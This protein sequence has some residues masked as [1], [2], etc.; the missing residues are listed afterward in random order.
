MIFV[1]DLKRAFSI[2]F[3]P[4]DTRKQDLGILRSLFLYYRAT[5]IAA[6]IMLLVAAV[7]ILYGWRILEPGW[8]GGLNGP[9]EDSA[10]STLISLWV[11]LPLS[12]FI[13]AGFCQFF[14]RLL[15]KFKKKYSKTLSGVIVG[16]VPA[17][18]FLLWTIPIIAALNAANSWLVPEGPGPHDLLLNNVGTFSLLVFA[19]AAICFFIC[20]SFAVANRQS[21]SRKA[22][23]GILFIASVV[24]YVLLTVSG[25]VYQSM[26]ISH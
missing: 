15:N 1:S 18:T 11:W 16:F 9:T 13:F 2:I 8:L 26:V 25:L 12:A 14:G 10:L 17:V 3:N 7:M 20:C 22:A 4:N 21:S 23:F 5:A 19:A 24:I 6:L